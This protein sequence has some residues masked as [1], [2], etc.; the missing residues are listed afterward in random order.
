MDIPHISYIR[1]V[2]DVLPDKIVVQR[3]MDDGFDVIESSLL[4]CLR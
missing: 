4:C 3:L 1:K 2:L